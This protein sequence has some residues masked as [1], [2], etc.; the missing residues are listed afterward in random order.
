MAMK[1]KSSFFLTSVEKSSANLSSS[2]MS[3]CICSHL[4]LRSSRS[5]MIDFRLR[6]YASDSRSRFC[7]PKKA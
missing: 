1:V 5:V 6:D 2:A 7:S 4:A 3:A